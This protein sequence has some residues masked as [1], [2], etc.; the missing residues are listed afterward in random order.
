MISLQLSRQAQKFIA[1]LPPKQRRQV[2]S[3]IY[4]LRDDPFPHDSKAMK[5]YA[6]FFRIDI[7]EYRAI[8]KVVNNDQ[9]ILV[10]VVGKRNDDEVY[11]I[12]KRKA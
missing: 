8:Y 11:R 7:G 12:L 4:A 5:G 10:A 2:V 3:Q 9:L 1:K 6:P